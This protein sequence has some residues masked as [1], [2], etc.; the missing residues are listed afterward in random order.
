MESLL[1]YLFLR[2]PLGDGFDSLGFTLEE[3]STF[4][5]GCARMLAAMDTQ[6]TLCAVREDF[7][8]RRRSCSVVIASELLKLRKSQPNQLLAKRERAGLVAR[9]V[10]V[11][12]RLRPEP[13]GMLV[14]TNANIVGDGTLQTFPQQ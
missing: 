7:L 6:A 1:P 12:G 9:R 14:G 3:C 10:E 4:R 11:G 2:A 13:E 5:C 8:Q